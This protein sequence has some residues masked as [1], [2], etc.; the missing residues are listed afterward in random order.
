MS[1]GRR[2]LGSH[3]WTG[4]LHLSAVLAITTFLSAAVAQSNRLAMVQFSN[5]EQAEG[6]LSLTPGDELKIHDGKEL[7]TLGL[8]VVQ[9]MVFE[10]EKETME[11]KWRFLEAGRTQKEKWGKPF[12]VREMRATVSVA[13]GTVIRGHVYTTVLYLEG[14]EQTTKVVLRAKDRGNEGQTFADIV[15]PVRISFSDRAPSVNGTIGIKVSD[16]EATELVALTPGALLRLPATRLTEG[17][18]FRLAGLLTSHL[19]LAVRTPSRITVGW[20]APADTGLVTRIEQGLGNA[21]DFFDARTLLGVHRSGD[22]VYSLLMLSRRKSTTLEA[23]ESQPWRL[24]IWRWKDNGERLMVAGRG[25][26]F[27]GILAKD[28]QPPPVSLSAAIWATELKDGME[29]P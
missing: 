28:E 22:D 21:E 20:P 13:D 17:P 6:T 7:K 10:P 1:T 24:E 11:Q 4:R 23:A 15:Y 18:T 26:F 29:L 14:K 3:G 12:P 16:A 9:D 8:D 27:R 19:F 2:N 5:G 25:F